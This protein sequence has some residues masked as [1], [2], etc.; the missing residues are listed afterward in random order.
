M[1]FEKKNYELHPSSF[2]V[3]HFFI[4]DSLL[5]SFISLVDKPVIDRS[6][7]ISKSASESGSSAKLICRAQGTPNVTFTWKRE[8][9]VIEVDSTITTSSS[10][11]SSSTSTTKSLSS[12]SRSSKTGK[13][14]S[15]TDF[16]VPKYEL[17]ETKQLDL[18]TYQSVLIVND[19]SHSDYGSYDCIARNE[20]GFDAFAIVLNR[21]S[22]PDSPRTL[23]VVNVTSGSVTLRW[24]AGF[25]GGLR[26]TFRLRYRAIGSN[27][28]EHYSYRDV[29]NVTMFVLNNLRDNTDYVFGVMAT[30]DKGDSDYSFETVQASTLKGNSIYIHNK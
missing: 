3:Y 18:I 8:G 16:T 25:D 27:V 7:I 30:N 22:R 24:M 12:K 13:I 11:S 6:P 20:L 23:R 9:S 29:S 4:V 2:N 19:V 21:T 14:S 26:Q 17:E 10:G 5:I 28:D 15:S 1:K